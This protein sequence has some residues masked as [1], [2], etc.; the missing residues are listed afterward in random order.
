[1]EA[2]RLR[3]ALDSERLEYGIRDPFEPAPTHAAPP[4]ACGPH[5]ISSY[6]TDE[7]HIPWLAEA[8]RE[9]P[10]VAN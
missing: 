5:N 2:E 9:C 7:F 3:D 4:A 10:R 6:Y 8:A 1:M